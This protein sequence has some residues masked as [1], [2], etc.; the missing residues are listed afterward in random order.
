MSER[1]PDNRDKSSRMHRKESV[2]FH[3]EVDKVRMAVG[4]N[5][6]A[7]ERFLVNKGGTASNSSL[8]G[9]VAFLFELFCLS[10]PWSWTVRQ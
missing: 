4:S 9:W 6:T 1:G 10:R 3:G 2:T 7:A 5:P 8:L